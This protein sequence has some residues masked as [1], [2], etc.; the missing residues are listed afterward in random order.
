M[1]N[2]TMEDLAK[3]K[4]AGRNQILL[5]QTAEKYST[6]SVKN[7][8]KQYPRALLQIKKQLKLLN[9]EF[10][11]EYRFD[12]KRKFRFDIAIINHK[13]A[14]EYEGIVSAKSRHTNITGYTNDCRKY[15]LAQALGWRV[16][17][18]TALNCEEF[19]SELSKIVNIEKLCSKSK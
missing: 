3:S 6:K 16:L 1:S 12:A 14:I 4:V 11:T 7:I 19:L 13:I 5:C 9:I 15:N 10:E 8:P 18:Y 17:R 2:W